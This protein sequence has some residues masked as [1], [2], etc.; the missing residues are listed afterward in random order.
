M[1]EKLLELQRQLKFAQQVTLS[2]SLSEQTVQKLHELR[3]IIDFDLSR[4]VSRK[5]YYHF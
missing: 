4:T 2:I 5:E 3:I 1:D